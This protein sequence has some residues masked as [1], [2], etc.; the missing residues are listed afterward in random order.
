M[1]NYQGSRAI[2]LSLSLIVTVS[3]SVQAQKSVASQAQRN[4][5]NYHYGDASEAYQGLNKRGSREA[6]LNAAV[7]LYKARRYDEALPLYRYSDSLSMIK[8]PAQLFGY[9][10]C[11]KSMKRYEEADKL[12]ST[13]MKDFG[14]MREFT[15]QSDKL[16]YYAKLLSFTGAK[17]EALPLNSAYS[18]IS[19]T[20]YNQWLY[21]VSTRP[22]T[23]NKQVHRIN[24]QPF[25]NMYTVPVGSDMEEA[26]RPAGAFG[27]PEKSIAYKNFNT[28]SLPEGINKEYHDGPIMATP[29]GDKIFFSTNWSDKKRPKEK[30]GHYTLLIYYSEKSGGIW[31]EPKPFPH[32]SFEYTTQHPFFDEK[33]STLYYSSNMPGGQGGHDIWKSSLKDGNWSVPENLGAGVNTPK[34]EVFPALTPEGK[35]IFSSNGWP[36]LGG[37]DIFLLHDAKLDP[38]NLMAGIN[39]EYDDFGLAFSGADMGYMVSSR[40]GGR[41]DDDIYSFTVDLKKVVKLM[42]PPKRLVSATLTDAQS[43]KPIEGATISISG[44]LNKSYVTGVDGTFRDS[45]SY[46]VLDPKYPEV[47]VKVEG[48]GYQTKEIRIA[49]WVEGKPLFDANVSLEKIPEPV[50]E[51]SPSEAA[52]TASGMNKVK[53]SSGNKGASGKAGRSGASDAAGPSGAD[54]TGTGGSQGN[55]S[56]TSASGQGGNTAGM[57]LDGVK[58]GEGHAIEGL[59]ESDSRFIIYFDFAKYGIRSDAAEILAKV[60]YVLLEE[61][62]DADVLISG[63][64]DS[65]GSQTYNEQLSK[66]RVE[67]VKKVLVSRGINPSR[68]RT[69]SH[70]E[71]KL[72]VVCNNPL[73][74]KDGD[75]ICFTPEEH[76]VSRRVELELLNTAGKK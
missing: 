63:H 52:A 74:R 41:G 66:N 4:E 30:K 5:Q 10:E 51:A 54:G 59:A 26:V 56:G 36:G 42:L 45:V 8:D 72:A 39:S 33:T 32:N 60:T 18:D 49:K 35:L 47:L 13:H 61:Y 15:L 21:F 37:L 25:Y 14:S 69:E 65:R 58:L 1:C 23:G 9:F 22:V 62:M 73:H 12:I 20:L 16:A 27:Q 31:S 57:T 70:G 40:K 48:A 28:T 76:R 68:I 38:L 64:T 43:G 3:A 55:Q 34:S 50:V 71:S 2:V 46:D 24:M 6:A 67:A 17:M 11:L 7:N 75:Y 29:S 19:P 44:N 53:G